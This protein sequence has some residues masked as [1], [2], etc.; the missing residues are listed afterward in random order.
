MSIHVLQRLVAAA[1]I[2]Y[3]ERVARLRLDH[4]A[5]MRETNMPSM[6]TCLQKLELD[7][8]TT[9]LSALNS[10]FVKLVAE[11]PLNWW[12]REQ[13]RGV[14]E[15][16]GTVTGEIEGPPVGCRIEEYTAKL[17]G[18]VLKLLPDQKALILQDDGTELEHDVS[19]YNECSRT[20]RFVHCF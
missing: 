4:P 11:L 12:K 5:Q 17:K 7:P 13:C 18:K 20:L 9:C 3:V 19:F 10:V 2:D 6:T 8:R 15:A 14:A 1:G 16:L